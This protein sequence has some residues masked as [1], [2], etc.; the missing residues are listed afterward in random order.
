MFGVGAVIF[1]DRT[2]RHEE[3]QEL[4]DGAVLIEAPSLT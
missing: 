4:D 3:Y 1:R 2:L